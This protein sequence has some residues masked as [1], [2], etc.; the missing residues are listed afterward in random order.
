MTQAMANPDACLTEPCAHLAEPKV[1]V[2]ELAP[3][4]AGGRVPCVTATTPHPMQVLRRPS[5]VVSIS[6]EAATT[7]HQGPLPMPWRGLHEV[8]VVVVGREHREGI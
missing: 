7:S 2:K 8:V 5:P 3:L 6:A 4:L 1:V